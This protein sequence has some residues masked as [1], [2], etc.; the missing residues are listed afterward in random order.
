MTTINSQEDFLRA[1]RDNP[2]WKEAVR[3]LI[4]G[5]ELL[6]LPARFN[7]FAEE[8]RQVNKRVES[9]LEGF[10]AFSEEQRQVN[11]RVETRLDRLESDVSELKAG[12]ARLEEGQ[13]RLEAGQARI[14]ARMT[15]QENDMSTVKAAHARWS[16]LRGAES[17]T[18]DMDIEYVKT[19][20]EADLV[21]M[22]KTGNPNMTRGELFSFR[23]ADLV[24]EAKDESGTVYIC[25]E[26]SYT[27]DL[28]GSDRA[29]RNARLLTEFTGHRSI[30]VVA[31][32]R[33]VR[34]VTALID[35]GEVY[36]YEIPERYMETE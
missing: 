33:N 17:I 24:V 1:L 16:A 8:Q 34:E 26:A 7:A 3:A 10:D 15:R 25:M 32:V 6:Q 36:W 20:S 11:K 4:L 5:E 14:E 12:Q 23:T 22:A 27:G 35:S 19:L 30:P 2:E 29:Q 31:S 18:I 9:R 13:A 21:R 28:R